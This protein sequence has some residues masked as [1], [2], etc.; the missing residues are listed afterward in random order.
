MHGGRTTLLDPSH[1]S[2][3]N[4]QLRIRNTGQNRPIDGRPMA[5]ANLVNLDRNQRRVNVFRL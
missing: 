1:R 2:F 4:L 5:G 3:V